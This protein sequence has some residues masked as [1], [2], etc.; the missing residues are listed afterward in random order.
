SPSTVYRTLVI[1]IDEILYSTTTTNDNNILDSFDRFLQQCTTVEESKRIHAQI[2][3]SGTYRFAFLA[4]RLISIYSRF[5]LVA[6]ARTVF[7]SIPVE[8]SFNI[9]LWNSILR[10]NLSHGHSEESLRLYVQMCSLGIFPDGF[11]F[12]LV[13]RACASLGNSKLCK[14]MHAHV[15][16]SGFQFHLHVAN[17]LMGMYAKIGKMCFGRKLFD[18][19][20][21]KSS[22]SWN[23][24]VSG[25]A[26][27]FDCDGALEIIG[28]MEEEGLEP[29]LVTWTSLLSAHARCGK[30]EEVLGLFGDMRMRKNGAT[31]E[32]IAV[33]LSVCAYFDAFSK[34]KEI[35]GYV[36][37]GGF[38]D[39]VFV[40]NSLICVYG[41]HGNTEAAKKLFSEI[42]IKNLVTWNALISSFAEAG[43]CDEASK[44]FSQLE[45]TKDQ[46]MR[47]DVVTWS[48]L[49]GGF[50]LKGQADKSLEFFRQMQHANVKPNSV[51]VASILS[52]CAEV[53]T[54]N[55][56]REIH[57]HV[58]RALMDKN[59]L[60]GN[61]LVNMYTKCGSLKQGHLVFD[62]I[63]NRDLISWNTM[64]LGYGMHGFGEDALSTFSQ[65][66]RARMEPDGITFVA[67]L[68]ACSHAGFV[69]EGREIFDRMIREFEV[70]PKM[71]HYA[72]MVDLLGRGGQLQEAIEIVKMMPMEPNECV[73]GALLNSCRMY[74]N[75]EVAEEIASRIFS[76][77]SETTGSYMLLSNIYA[78]CG[79]WEDSAKVRWLA[80]SKGLKKS[81]GQSWIEVHKKVYMFSAGNTFHL[82]LNEVYEILKDLGLRM[83]IEGYVPDKSFVL[84]DVAEEEKKQILYGHS[85]KLAI[86]FGHSKLTS[87]MPIRVIKNLRVCGDCHNWT[88][89]FSKMTKR[90]VIVRDG[91]RFHH[92][93]DGFCSCKDYW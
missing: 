73:W 25:F 16:L 2:I 71:E 48:A 41:K 87:S 74:R 34:G 28:M 10:A 8:C 51:T 84:Q 52:V 19:M 90:E 15:V 35:H 63:K 54:L 75:T 61:G 46:L 83:E 22:T 59:I 21:H 9:L 33:V 76:L 58:I 88:K 11:T 62:W 39:Y 5:G 77:A 68:S 18:R 47:P 36:I 31:A 79:R 24:I 43:F 78:A 65:M 29:N 81:T 27:N 7:C 80:R 92:F 57:C 4:A 70:P 66:V 93:M 17:E 38:E 42:K 26:L 20:P 85:E 45:N 37:K 40:K 30:H 32:A 3:L 67:L 82:D 60:V 72:C 49:I 50:S 6:D 55:L 23:T 64:I 13:V 86:A 44:I 91:R 53:A 69:N 12:P 14:I 1:Q 89:F 56:G